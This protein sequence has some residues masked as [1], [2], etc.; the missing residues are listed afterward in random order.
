MKILQNIIYLFLLNV[1]LTFNKVNAQIEEDNSD[2]VIAWMLAILF[3]GS[4]ATML[5]C[6]CTYDRQTFSICPHAPPNPRNDI[7]QP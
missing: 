5:I 2:N 4:V 3:I 1:F 6:F 7:E